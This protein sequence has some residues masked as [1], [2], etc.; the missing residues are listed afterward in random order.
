MQKIFFVNVLTLFFVEWNSILFG[1]NAMPVAIE[2]ASRQHSGLFAAAGGSVSTDVW[3]TPLP[4]PPSLTVPP[5]LEP[6]PTSSFWD[7]GSDANR[8]GVIFAND[9]GQGGVTV[10]CTEGFTIEKQY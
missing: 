2:C 5:S 10:F 3:V 6:A 8:S 7:K 1:N 4:G 9:I